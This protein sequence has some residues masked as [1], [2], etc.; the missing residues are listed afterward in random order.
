[1]ISFA[2]SLILSRLTVALAVADLPKMNS[3]LTET[4]KA[5]IDEMVGL[6]D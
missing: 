4:L 3:L 5:G 2:V 6:L 1:M